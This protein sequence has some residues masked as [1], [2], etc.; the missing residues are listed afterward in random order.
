MI[1]LAE[2]IPTL[3]RLELTQKTLSEMTNDT[4]FSIA[5]P[6]QINETFRMVVAAL[7]VYV[8]WVKNEEHPVDEALQ[9]GDV[10]YVRTLVNANLLAA[11][12]RF[13]NYHN[14]DSAY[15][16]AHVAG[17]QIS[18]TQPESDWTSSYYPMAL[19]TKSNKQFR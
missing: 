18:L 14:P 9:A 5:H 15:I 7:E 10:V 12:E 13:N 8:E 16:V 2:H 17:A 3:E 4:G 19:F 1:K 11:L 6:E